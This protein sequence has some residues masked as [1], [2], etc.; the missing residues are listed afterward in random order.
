MPFVIFRSEP[1]GVKM[2]YRKKRCI[3]RIFAYQLLHLLLGIFRSDGGRLYLT[4]GSR[5]TGSCFQKDL[6]FPL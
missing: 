6:F 1:L 2:I 4:G 3:L 5:Q